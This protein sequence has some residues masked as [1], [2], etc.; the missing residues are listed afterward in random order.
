M[1][2]SAPAKRHPRPPEPGPGR[3]LRTTATV[4]FLLAVAAVVWIGLAEGSV[5]TSL[6][7]VPARAAGDLLSGLAAGTLLLVLTWVARRFLP[8]FAELEQHLAA[9][10]PG[11]TRGEALAVAAIS[12]FAEELFF[13]GAVQGSWGWLWAAVLFALLHTG[14]DRL[15]GPWSVF[16][17]LAGSLFA[18]L[19]LLRGSILPAVVAHILVNAVGLQRLLS[20]RQTPEPN[21]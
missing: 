6:F 10:L 11:V 8:A 5:P 15:V 1:T 4:Y 2:D 21:R 19:T 9:L 16:A 14:P 18:G 20:S 13:R 12:G 7:W 3:F 17:L